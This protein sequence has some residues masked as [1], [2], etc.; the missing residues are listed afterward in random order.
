[1]GSILVGLG[2]SPL[3]LVRTHYKPF[4]LIFLPSK[5]PKPNKETWK[6]VFI[7]TISLPFLSIFSSHKTKLGLR[8][9]K[10]GFWKEEEEEEEEESK[11]AREEA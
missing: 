9:K 6:L 5:T 10:R 7:R 4:L 8:E 11:R 1:M 3:W 2:F